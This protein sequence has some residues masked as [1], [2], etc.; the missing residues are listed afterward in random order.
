MS[1]NPE[2]EGRER[3]SP[4]RGS[5]ADALQDAAVGFEAPD[6]ARLHGAAVRRGTQIRRRRAGT[7]ALVGGTVALGTAGA[8]AFALPPGAG[9]DATVTTANSAH[10]TA[11]PSPTYTR[12]TAPPVVTPGAITGTV[13]DDALEYTLPPNAQVIQLGGYGN[14]NIEVVDSRAHTWYVQNT[15]TI[16]SSGQFGTLIAISVSHTAEPDTCAALNKAETDDKGT[17]TQTTVAGGKLLE[18]FVPTGIMSSDGV[19]EFFE[20]FSPAGYET[21]V[22]LQDSTVADFALTNA[23][24]GAIMA[25]PVFGTI[26][27][28]LPADACVGGSF[29]DPVDPP[30]PGSSPLQHVRCSTDGKLYPSF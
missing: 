12:P 1:Q 8:L 17:C 30:S 11:T 9:H 6:T 5:F 26:A 16:K 23:Q 27:R 18:E 7:A 19:F 14:V 28:A 25:N 4:G 15:V 22:E 21:D 20:W 29:S 3:E 13:V 24:T 2:W 10:K